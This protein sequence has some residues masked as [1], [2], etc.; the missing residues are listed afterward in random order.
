MERSSTEGESFALLLPP[1]A[2]S[3]LLLRSFAASSKAGGFASCRRAYGEA[4]PRLYTYVHSLGQGPYGGPA[5][6]RSLGEASLRRHC[7]AKLRLIRKA[8]R[9][10]AVTGQAKLA[11]GRRRIFDSSFTL[12]SSVDQ[13]S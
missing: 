1:K 13:R 2:V 10:L 12:R 7:E 5:L 11:R 6:V 3:S 8:S 9:R 4:S